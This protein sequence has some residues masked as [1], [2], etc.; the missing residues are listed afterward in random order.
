[1]SVSINGSKVNSLTLLFIILTII[2]IFLA[3]IGVDELNL[4]GRK[5][6][7]LT[8]G[9]PFLLVINYLLMTSIKKALFAILVFYPIWQ[10]PAYYI[11]LLSMPDGF[12]ILNLQQAYIM[13]ISVIIILAGLVNRKVRLNSQ[14]LLCLTF[15]LLVLVFSSIN[16]FVSG[17]DVTTYNFNILIVNYYIPSLLFIGLILYTYQVDRRYINN[18]ILCFIIFQFLFCFI[19]LIFRGK[20][21]LSNPMLFVTYGLRLPSGSDGSQIITGGIRD[22]LYFAWFFSWLPIYFFYRY[23]NGLFSKKEYVFWMFFSY[24]VVLMTYSKSPIIILLINTFIILKVDGVFSKK[25]RKKL[26]GIALG[27]TILSPFI[28]NNFYSRVIQFIESVT[29]YFTMGDNASR[30]VDMTVYYRLKSIADQ[31]QYISNDA[32]NL[33]FGGFNNFVEGSS[34]FFVLSSFGFIALLIIIIISLLYFIKCNIYQKGVFLSYLI[35]SIT[36]LESFVGVSNHRLYLHSIDYSKYINENGWY[37]QYSM[38]N[39]FITIVLFVFVQ[40]IL[41]IDNGENNVK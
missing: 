8:L 31:L 40:K 18:A 37:P 17:D 21:I 36:S 30:E 41:L 5:I 28:I 32:S 3:L 15:S 39:V 7:A 23:K 1:M 11:K 10:R 35:Y 24:V 12:Y 2:T 38:G 9:L 26:I 20:I 33:F 25:T 22:L 29:V 4:G 14:E 27:I 13:I 19:E 16:Y 6:A 34:L